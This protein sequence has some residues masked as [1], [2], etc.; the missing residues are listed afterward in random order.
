MATIKLFSV[1]D[2]ISSTKVKKEKKVH[3]PE[4]CHIDF[5]VVITLLYGC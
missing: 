3:I 2:P 4:G 5:A 1:F